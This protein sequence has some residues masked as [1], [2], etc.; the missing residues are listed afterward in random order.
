M[1]EK[2]ASRFALRRIRGARRSN[3]GL[4]P[5]PQP[6]DQPLRLLIVRGDG[7]EVLHGG[8]IRIDAVVLEDRRI[9]S[10]RCRL[11][12]PVGGAHGMIQHR[13]IAEGYTADPASGARW[14]ADRGYNDAQCQTDAVGPRAAREYRQL[15]ADLQDERYSVDHSLA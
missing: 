1:R 11:G 13:C 12:A 9:G 7:V 15:Y 2:R 8:R 14:R 5:R 10:A 6:V 3:S 4:D